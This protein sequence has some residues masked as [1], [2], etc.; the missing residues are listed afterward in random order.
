MRTA[1]SWGRWTAVGAVAAV[2]GCTGGGETV[3]TGIGNTGNRIG[4]AAL[5]GA[6]GE[7]LAEREDIPRVGD[8]DVQQI[9][10]AIRRRA[11]EG[12]LDAALVMLEVAAAQGDDD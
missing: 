4:T 3:V 11:L 9:F 7:A 5:W 6:L 2:L 10:Q 1:W 8:P 12:E